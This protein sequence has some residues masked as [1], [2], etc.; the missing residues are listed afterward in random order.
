MTEPLE[1]K[2]NRTTFSTHYW[3]TGPEADVLAW[4][5]RLQKSYHPCGYGTYSR[6]KTAHGACK[7]TYSAYRQNS[8]D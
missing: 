1:I 3:V 5:G 7:V 6:L 8:C 4:C 2:I